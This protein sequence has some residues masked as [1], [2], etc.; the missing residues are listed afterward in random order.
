LF[1]EVDITQEPCVE[2]SL[3]TARKSVSC[4][5]AG[6]KIEMKIKDLPVAASLTFEG[7]RATLV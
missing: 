3:D 2:T 7:E 1:L 5:A 4:P 6:A